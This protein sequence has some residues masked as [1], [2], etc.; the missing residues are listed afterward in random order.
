M[1]KFAEVLNREIAGIETVLYRRVKCGHHWTEKIR[2]MK[3][4]CMRCFVPYRFGFATRTWFEARLVRLR[5][6]GALLKEN[7][8][9]C[10]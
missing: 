7:P 1:A 3:R 4:H 6:I 9:P 8:P 2:G 10:D 5:H